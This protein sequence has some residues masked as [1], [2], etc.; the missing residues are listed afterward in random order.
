MHIKIM[1]TSSQVSGA[2]A[3]QRQLIA[4]EGAGTHLAPDRV[5]CKK[6]ISILREAREA[7]LGGLKEQ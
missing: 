4:L 3:A 2:R 1:R 5:D 6:S 7:E